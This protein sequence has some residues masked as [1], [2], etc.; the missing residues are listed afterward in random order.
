MTA[1]GPV[2]GA[3]GESALV[4]PTQNTG[5]GVILSRDGFIVTNAHVIEGGRRFVG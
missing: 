2:A 1:Y 5:S 4:G 3:S